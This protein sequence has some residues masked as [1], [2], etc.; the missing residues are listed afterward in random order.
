M[1]LPIHDNLSLEEVQERF[2]DCY[3]FLR[4]KFYSVAHKRYQPTDKTYALDSKKKIG[5]V[6]NVHNNG[7]L[8]IKSWHTVALVE[9]ELKDEFGLNAQILRSD[10]KGQWT[11]TS[12]SDTLTLAEQSAIGYDERLNA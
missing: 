12:L 6:R 4:I 2:T 9:K 1:F 10:R 3:P 11:Q 8:E 7:A 5:D